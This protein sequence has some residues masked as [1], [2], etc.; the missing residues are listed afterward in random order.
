[1]EPLNCGLFPIPRA[2]L[3]V[4]LGRREP[5][6]PNLGASVG[7]SLQRL[8]IL[9]EMYTLGQRYLNQLRQ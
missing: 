4:G 6:P 5:E 2:V 1:M 7:E 3:R 8:Y 9:Q